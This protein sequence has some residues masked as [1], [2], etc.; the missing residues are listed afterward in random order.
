[1]QRTTL[2]KNREVGLV[3][4]RGRSCSTRLLVLIYIVRRAGGVRAGFSVSK[5]VGKSV[6][7]N[8][9]RRQLKE[10]FRLFMEDIP[11]N[12]DMIFLARAP[13][14]EA[15]FSAIKKDMR[16]LLKKARLFEGADEAK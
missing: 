3:Y 7:R 1:M 5:K 10:A 15:D 4:S 2:K 9:K 8:R 13:I 14:A 11:M 16:Y 12:V 6:V